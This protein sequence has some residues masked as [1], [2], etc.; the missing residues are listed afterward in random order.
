MV[1]NNGPCL[2]PCW[3]CTRRVF[4]DDP[5]WR[6]KMRQ[7]PTFSKRIHAFVYE[8]NWGREARFGAKSPIFGLFWSCIA[9]P[10][11]PVWPLV[12]T[13]QGV[14]FVKFDPKWRQKMRQGQIFR[15][16]TH[17]FVNE[18]NWG[19]ETWFGAKSPIFGSICSLLKPPSR[20]VWPLPGA[21]QGVFFEKFDPK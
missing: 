1:C 5:K 16:C 12:G 9:F 17:A 3:D 13:V 19:R 15:K 10:F 2:T 20:G 7:G 14:F 18:Q 8:Q 6:Q 11:M 21:V 4:R